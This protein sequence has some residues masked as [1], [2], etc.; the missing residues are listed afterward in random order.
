M[1]VLS[2]TLWRTGQG[3]G[4][5]QVSLDWTRITNTNV[6][7]T[8]WAN[9]EYRSYEF[10][11][12]DQSASIEETSRSEERRRGTEKSLTETERI[13]LKDTARKTF[14]AEEFADSE[15]LIKRR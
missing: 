7:G 10:K 12:D 11:G 9:V 3:T 14:L 8:G 6:L 2:I 5:A 1:E 15:C 4:K 13:K